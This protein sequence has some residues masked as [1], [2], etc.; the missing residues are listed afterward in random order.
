MTSLPPSPESNRRD[1]L[2][3]PIII[4]GSPRSGT[5]ILGKI[6]SQHPD[7]VYV[8]E[9]RLTWRLGNDKGSDMLRGSQARPEVIRDIRKS[10]EQFVREGDGHRLLEKTPS[11]ALRMEFVDRVFPDCKFIHITRNGLDSVL[12]IRKFWLD[13]SGG[14]KTH[15]IKERLKEIDIRRAPHY[16]REMAR[17]A[18]PKWMSGVVGP[19]VW[20]PRLPGLDGLVRDLDLLEVCALQ[21]RMCVEAAVHYG[22]T[23]PPDRYLQFRLEDIA[24]GTLPQILEFCDLRPDAEMESF[25]NEKFDPSLRGARKVNADEAEIRHIMSWIEPTMQWLGYD[26]DV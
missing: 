6:L 17:R 21:W 13:H 8:E 26:T 16:A 23:L 1:E 7:L 24:L 19:K 14:I 10:F 9:P 15:K 3:C 18:A 20:G 5:T 2:A 11:N 22:R 4:I 25:F 12:S